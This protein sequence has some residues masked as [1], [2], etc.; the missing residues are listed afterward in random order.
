[1]KKNLLI[2][3]LCTMVNFLKAQ[4]TY[5]WPSSGNI[6]IGTTSP[7]NTLHVN[8]GIT[9]TNGSPIFSATP[10]VNL[11]YDATNDKSVLFS[12]QPTVS[13]KPFLFGA[14]TFSFVSFGTNQGLFQDANG[15]VGIGTANLFGGKL[16]VLSSAGLSPLYLAGETNEGEFLTA[17]KANGSYAT[18][19]Y[20]SGG[21]SATDQ[22]LRVGNASGIDLFNILYNG[23]FGIGAS[24]PQS[25][26]QVDD[27]CTKAS[28]GDAS[29]PGLNYGTSY[30]GFNATRNS[31]NIWNISNDSQHNGAGVIY[32]NIMGDIYFAPITS[33]G[34]TDQT[35]SDADIKSKITFR[36]AA[37]GI[38]YAKK[39]KVELTDWPDYVFHPKYVLKPLS[40]VKTYIDQNHHL[41]D[42][43]SAE[44]IEK[45]G[46]DVGEMN[47]LLTKKVEE[48]TLYLIE[49]QKINQSLQQQ[50]DA[51]KPSK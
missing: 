17:T 47:K 42:M 16:Q 30:L 25:L 50:I 21:S 2:V 39:I 45:D 1:M 44:K 33:T 34:T 24:N 28:I 46:L 3:A 31:S 35:L 32:S 29:G 27:G 38:T 8:G 12:I 4:N 40:D 19:F 49:Q 11:Y 10:S 14:Q 37:D 23:N 26:F 5:P 51:L 15:N 13:W 9:S 43:P 6:G 36:V 7:Q 41:P 18:H 22:A 20:T 48:L